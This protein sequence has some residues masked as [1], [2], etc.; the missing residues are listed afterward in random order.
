M[1]RDF[2]NIDKELKKIELHYIFSGKSHTMDAVVRNKC[3]YEFLEI[4]KQIG[5]LI[6]VDIDI[7]SEAYLQG[8]LKEWW[9]ILV[10]KNP[11]LVNIVIGVLIG[12]I[13]SHLTTDKEL[14]E[15]H[16]QELRLSIEYLKHEIKDQKEE[17]AEI[18]IENAIFIINNDIK[19]LKHKSN[20]YN[21]LNNYPKV[22]RIET[23][24]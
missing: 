3:E 8:G 17:Q 13:T 10:K 5:C 18:N 19:V 22:I 6:D 4:V 21:A 24:P 1:K 2:F 16:K 11:Q 7:E 9:T 23:V 12:V 14:T 15:L 20:F